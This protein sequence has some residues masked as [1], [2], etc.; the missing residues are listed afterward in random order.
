MPEM[1]SFEMISN[2]AIRVKTA[3]NFYVD[4]KIKHLKKVSI[5]HNNKKIGAIPSVSLPAIITC[6]KNAPCARPGSACYAQ[7]MER[8]TARSSVI[9]SYYKNYLL[10]LNDPGSYFMQIQAAAITSAFFR[11][12]VSGD[13]PCDD[14]FLRMIETAQKVPTC[15]FLVF[16]KQFKI[17]N[18]YIKNG[19]VIPSNLI[20]IFSNWFKWKCKNNYN[21]PQC[22][23][24][25]NISQ[26][27]TGY[28]CTGSCADC[29]RNCA[30]CFN[31]KS[32]DIINIKKH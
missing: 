24:V 6:N 4:I 1:L 27:K 10:Y 2:D 15:K 30:G 9:K 18:D 7:H 22:E 8:N 14:Y 25:E 20:I 29:I 28:I 19:G 23:I 13:I 21:M 5:S 3:Y 32:G 12:H 26:V 11:Y 16:T 17:V 31:A